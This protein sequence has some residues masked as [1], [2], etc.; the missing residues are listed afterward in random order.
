MKDFLK[1]IDIWKR[2]GNYS[3]WNQS[4]EIMFPD[5]FLCNG[6]FFPDFDDVFGQSLGGNP[7]PQ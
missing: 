1:R 4:R 3:S 7:I 2:V 5:S 6:R